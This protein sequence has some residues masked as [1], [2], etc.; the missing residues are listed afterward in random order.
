M[1]DIN[2]EAWGGAFNSGGLS[3]LLNTTDP[4]RRAA[5]RSWSGSGVSDFFRRGVPVQSQA[6]VERIEGAAA[7][8]RNL[9]LT[10]VV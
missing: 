8:R 4:D 7:A 1:T 10:P 5:P 6:E 9:E 3:G 2:R